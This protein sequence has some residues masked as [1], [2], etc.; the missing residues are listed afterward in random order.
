M[1]HDVAAA[2]Y[3]AGAHAARNNR[4]VGGHAAANGQDALCVVHALDIFRGGFQTDQN[5]L[6]ALLAFLGGFLSGEDNLAAGS[7][8]GSSQTGADLFCVLERLC[9]KLWVQQRVKLFWIDHADGLFLGDHALVHQVAGDLDGSGSGSL[10]VSGLQH[11]ELAVFDGELHI[12]HVSVV[13]LQAVSNVVELLINLWHNGFQL[14]DLLWGTNAGD[15]VLALCVD[16][17]L[18][19]QLV[20]AGGRVA[21]EG[22][23]GTGGVAGVAEYHGLNVDRSAPGGRDVVHSSVVDRARV[24]PGAEYGLDRAHQLL[25]W[26]LWEVGAD[27]LFVVGFKFLDHLF[28]VVGIQLGVEL[29]ALSG[30]HLVDDDF[31]V[32]L[33]NFHN[34]VGVHLDEAAV[35]VISKALVVGHLGKAFDNLIVEAQVQ[36]GVHHARHGSSGAGT[37]RNQQRVVLVAKLFAG[38]LLQLSQ[39]LKDLRLDFRADLLAVLIVLGAGLSG[40]GEALRNRHAQNGH[41]S[42]VGTLAA[43]Q[44]THLGVALGESINKFLAQRKNLPNE[45]W[46]RWIGREGIFP[47]FFPAQKE[48]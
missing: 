13:F 38:Q 39:I 14:V 16:Q 37:D 35:G 47:D 20:L 6:L 41:L 45:I 11:V 32:V 12:L 27:L 21:G 1:H 34:N 31:E 36:D 42:K 4:R 40:D 33:W 29:D 17:E 25:F 26:I 2:G 10:A 30:L 22:Y 44:L 28:E 18:A 8:R 9:V 48:L 19:E 3:A 5:N 23:A 7:A 46:K 43:E 15:N 24:I